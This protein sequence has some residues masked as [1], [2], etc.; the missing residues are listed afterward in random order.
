MATSS[1]PS[2]ESG[3]SVLDA[4]GARLHRARLLYVRT[5]TRPERTAVAHAESL[6]E[7]AWDANRRT[8]TRGVEE[9]RR[10]L[11]EAETA[12][13]QIFDAVLDGEVEP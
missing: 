1:T 8:R 11:A 5:A 9:A 13:N 7:R 2:H 6:L 3:D 12:S 4:A 10:K